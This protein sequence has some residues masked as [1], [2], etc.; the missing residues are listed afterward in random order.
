MPASVLKS[1]VQTLIQITDSHLFAEPAG[2]LL[3]L[4]T[5]ASLEAVVQLAALEHPDTRLV[6]A[7]GDISQDA[8]LESY[9]HFVQQIGLIN[10]PMRWLPGNHDEAQ[11]QL[12][13][14]AGADWSQPVTDL[15][16][17]R[18]IMLDSSVSGA[19]FGQLLPEQ[20]QLLDDALSSAGERHVLVCM[21]HHPV[22]ISCRW[23]DNLGLR[24][25]DAFFSVLDRFANVRAVLWGHIH[26]EL[27]IERQG[28]RLLATPS[29]C[30]Q[31]APHSDEF[32]LDR[33]LPGYRWLRLHANGRIET[34]V[35]RLQQLDYTIDFSQNGY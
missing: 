31:F 10:A 9:Q 22:P 30:I 29:T 1:D 15:P 35:S 32:A 11:V 27:D 14:S 21:H 23:L 33:L 34:G 17:W 12:Q 20:L 4:P 16:G 7:T 26:Q 6:L 3:G 25:A 8:T 13:A 24:N 18:I 19:V 5:R 28:V 2:N